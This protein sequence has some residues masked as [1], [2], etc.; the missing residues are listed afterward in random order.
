MSTTNVLASATIP[1]SIGTGPGVDVSTMVEGKTF[2]LPPFGFGVI[3]VEASAD[4]DSTYAP[5]LTIQ[6]PSGEPQTSVVNVACDHIRVRRLSGNDVDLNL[7]IAAEV[8]DPSFATLPLSDV[9]PGDVIFTELFYGKKT[10]VVTGNFDG[11]VVVSGSAD[12]SSFNP[13]QGVNIQGAGVYTFEGTYQFM[14]IESATLNS[15]GIDSISVAAVGVSNAAVTD[16]ER[17]SLL[18]GGVSADL[19]FDL[20]DDNKAAGSIASFTAIPSL[21][22]GVPMS[23]FASPLFNS[24]PTAVVG[25]SETKVWLR[26]DQ[27]TQ[28][29]TSF[30]TFYVGRVGT[31]VSQGGTTPGD[32]FGSLAEMAVFFYFSARN[33][34]SESDIVIL[35]IAP[36][37]TVPQGDFALAFGTQ[38]AIGVEIFGGDVVQMVSPSGFAD[39]AQGDS[40]AHVNKCAGVALNHCLSTGDADGRRGVIVAFG[41]ARKF[42]AATG[43]TFVSGDSIWISTTEPGKVTNVDTTF[44]RIG[45]CTSNDESGLLG[46][47]LLK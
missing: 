17:T 43:I 24:T 39:L 18:I 33:L 44:T 8:G 28:A 36:N 42:N 20:P 26:I 6:G 41:D 34:Q 1:G 7:D 46:I 45:F 4:S 40:Q 30:E 12:G 47:L 5:F 38:G 23:D 27:I 9:F 32:G 11:S 13:V 37:P 22:V 10:L 25:T 31:S 3:T 21:F 16:L 29:M 35:D 19:T 2:T 15:G 14:R